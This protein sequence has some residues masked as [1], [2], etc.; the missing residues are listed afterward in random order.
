MQYF[1]KGVLFGVG[2]LAVMLMFIPIQVLA[3]QLL[4]VG[5]N[6]V[7]NYQITPLGYEFV[8]VSNEY[9]PVELSSMLGVTVNSIQS[10]RIVVGIEKKVMPDGKTYDVPLLKNGKK[11]VFATLP[12]ANV[13]AKLDY[14]YGLQGFERVGGKSIVDTLQKADV[15]AVR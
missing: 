5:N 6:D 15:S 10:G 7:G 2:M 8:W 13:T 1:K 14:Q 12:S 11:V 9:S 4:S 3:S